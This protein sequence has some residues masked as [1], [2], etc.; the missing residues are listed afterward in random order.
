MGKTARYRLD[1]L[2][3]KRGLADSVTIAQAMVMAGEVVVDEQRMD[4][5]GTSITDNSVIRLKDEG[6]FVSRGGDKLDAAI[7]DLGLASLF[8]DKVILDVGASTGG[9]TD[10]VLARGARQVIALDV[11][12]AQLAWKLRQDPRVQSVEK[13]DVK[14]FSPENPQLFDWVVADLSFTSLSKLI[15]EIQR[16]APRAA[17][18]LLVK[19]QFERPRDMIPKGGVVTNNDDRM[20]ALK[21]VKDALLEAGYQIIGVTEARITGR[22]GNREIF[23]CGQPI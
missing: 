16:S 11:G 20:N 17:V 18:L 14:N 2:M 7:D 23:I 12:T 13:T 21:M 15:P 1:E 19:P 22:Q 6:R 10:C 8:K 3:V 5:P 9:F 4:K